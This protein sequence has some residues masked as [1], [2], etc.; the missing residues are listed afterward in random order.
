M[1]HA[2]MLASFWSV[3]GSSSLHF[4]CSLAAWPKL[5]QRPQ[6]NNNLSMA[7]F[8]YRQKSI[9]RYFLSFVLRLFSPPPSLSC[10]RGSD[11]LS[12]YSQVTTAGSFRPFFGVS[13][14]LQLL[15]WQT[16]DRPGGNAWRSSLMK[17]HSDAFKAA[18]EK[19]RTAENIGSN[20]YR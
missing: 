14:E 19:E 11:H 4:P 5:K 6:V 9:Y 16:C 8:H 12:P 18:L 15:D 3:F 20:M 17:R 1:I 10:D 13:N 2:F 7:V